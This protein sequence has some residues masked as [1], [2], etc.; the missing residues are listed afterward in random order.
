M[1][2]APPDGPTAKTTLQPFTF[3]VL[4]SAKQC[5]DT[6]V[7]PATLNHSHDQKCVWALIIRWNLLLLPVRRLQI[8]VPFGR[9]HYWSLV[10]T[11]FFWQDVTWRLCVFQSLS[12]KLDEGLIF[13]SVTAV[14][15]PSHQIWTLWVN[16]ARRLLALEYFWESEYVI[17]ARSTRSLSCEDNSSREMGR[18]SSTRSQYGVSKCLQHAFNEV[19]AIFLC[20]LYCVITCS[21]CCSIVKSMLGEKVIWTWYSLLSIWVTLWVSAYHSACTFDCR[22]GQIAAWL[23]L[24]WRNKPF[25]NILKSVF[26][27]ENE[28]VSTD[29]DGPEWVKGGQRIDFFFIWIKTADRKGERECWGQGWHVLKGL[30]W[31]WTWWRLRSAAGPLAIWYMYF[32]WSFWQLQ[33]RGLWYW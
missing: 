27:F 13:S 17:T 10:V 21:L 28:V 14:L 30:R 5:V 18:D 20:V 31:R 22:W 1:V 25:L 24:S 15:G 33:Q 32:Y 12:G 29:L 3:N 9:Y 23:A 8:T 7:T 4:L 19:I 11:P 16:V 2:T 6:H 26:M